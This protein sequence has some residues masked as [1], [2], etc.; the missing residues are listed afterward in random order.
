MEHAGVAPTLMNCRT[1]LLLEHQHGEVGS[2]FQQGVRSRQSD[3]PTADHDDIGPTHGPERRGTLP[4]VVSCGRMA[5]WS[6]TERMVPVRTAS[7][8]RPT[9]D[10]FGYEWTKF[11]QSR[12]DPAEL[13]RLFG[14]YFALFPWDAVGPTAVGFDL[15][16][17]SGR[18]ARLAAFRTAGVVGVDASAAAL[19]VAKTNAGCPS[20]LAAAGALPFRP[21]SLDFG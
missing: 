10:G 18:W 5:R 12:A 16:C 13:E 9:V 11:D 17:G 7:V 1:S 6:P 4:V 2:R 20:V 14:E 15:G 21:G 3:D 19:R 8:D